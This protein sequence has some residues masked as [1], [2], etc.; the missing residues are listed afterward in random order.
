[1]IEVLPGLL[2]HLAQPNTTMIEVEPSALSEN[3]KPQ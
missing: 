3:I 1:M 2:E